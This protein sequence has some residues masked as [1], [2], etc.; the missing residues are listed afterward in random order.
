MML[1]QDATAC[2]EHEAT[3]TITKQFTL[4]SALLFTGASTAMAAS[5]SGSTALALAGVV[6]QY[7]PIPA[8]N[9]HAAASFFK[10]DTHFPFYGKIPVAADKIVCRTSNVDLTA[11]S[12]DITFSTAKRSLKGRE[13][14]ELFAT[15]AMAGVVAEGAA[16]S[17][18]ETVS[19]LNCVLDSKALKAKAGSG[20]ECTFEP[21][22]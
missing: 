20:A 11:R 12:C 2:G 4:A 1:A 16:G 6:A 15:L 3:M 19:K 22:N 8:A 7:A 14:N 5:V 9:K 13:A 21:G 17:N 18:I 10:G